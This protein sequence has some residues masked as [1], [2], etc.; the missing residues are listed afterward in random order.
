MRGVGGSGLN[1]FTAQEFGSYSRSSSHWKLVK[2]DNSGIFVGFPNPGN[3]RNI[4]INQGYEIQIDDSDAPDR[5]TGSIYT[6]KGADRA[7]VLGR[8]EAAGVKW[9]S[10]TRSRSRARTSRCS[11]NGVLVENDFT[12]VELICD[13]TQGFVGVQNR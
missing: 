5:L 1:W 2:D 11:L 8:A 10:S 12:S 13:L 7:A 6:F 3:D 9:N 4:A